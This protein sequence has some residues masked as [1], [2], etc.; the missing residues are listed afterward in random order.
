MY[1]IMCQG[2]KRDNSGVLA[3]CG[4]TP[5]WM[6]EQM[7]SHDEPERKVHLYHCDHRGLP[8]ALIS[9]ANTVACGV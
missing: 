6:A 2:G 1:K 9:P 7:E 3:Q 4:L 8:L 5:K